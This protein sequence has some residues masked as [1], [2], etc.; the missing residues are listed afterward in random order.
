MLHACKHEKRT[1]I[2]INIIDYHKNSNYSKFRWQ[3][4]GTK[5]ILRS[6]HKRSIKRS[7][8]KIGHL[9]GSVLVDVAILYYGS[10]SIEFQM[11]TLENLKP[12][13]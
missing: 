11:S 1:K 2:M 12:Y 4:K 13:V 6:K 9:L 8:S 10:H 5:I 3:I 7:L